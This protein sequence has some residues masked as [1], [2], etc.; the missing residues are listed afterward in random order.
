MDGLI[1]VNKDKGMLSFPVVQSIRAL[2]GEKKVGHTGTLDPQATGLL[3]I[4]LG[5]ATRLVEMIMNGEK[6]YEGEFVFGVRTDT[7]V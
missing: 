6:T 5:R 4:C 3:I 1:L 7:L 2:S